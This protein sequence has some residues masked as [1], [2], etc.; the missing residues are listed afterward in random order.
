MYLK[1]AIL[2]GVRPLN[3][4]QTGYAGVSTNAMDLPPGLIANTMPK[5]GWHDVEKTFRSDWDSNSKDEMSMG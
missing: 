4:G 3:F 1:I 2:F 5:S